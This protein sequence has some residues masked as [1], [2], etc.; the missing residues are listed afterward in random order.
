MK[1]DD[2]KLSDEQHASLLGRITRDYLLGRTPIPSSAQPVA[3]L[4]GGQPGSG[5][6]YLAAMALRELA[7]NAVRIDSDELRGYHPAYSRLQRQGARDAADLVHPDAGKWAVELTQAAVDGRYNLVIDGTMRDHAGV[8]RMATALQQ[9]GYRVEARVLAVNGY[10]SYMQTHAR[11]EM[12]MANV[13]LGRPTTKATH[14][15]AYSG[16]PATLESLER[17]NAVDAITLFNRDHGV[18]Y[19]NRQEDGQWVKMP[20]ARQALDIERG[21]ELTQDEKK[22]LALGWASVVNSQ[23]ARLAPSKDIEA[24]T[25]LAASELK[26]AASHGKGRGFDKL[27]AP[28]ETLK[29]QPQLVG[30]YA[31]LVAMQVEAKRQQL[32]IVQQ[33]V[34][35]RLAR[36]VDQ[37]TKQKPSLVKVSAKSKNNDIER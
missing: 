5:K 9:A 3:I 6:S 35:A 17:S 37:R 25:K 13:G 8:T 18:I 27:F 19:A 7:G 2:Y 10:V 22:E 30:R 29:Q 36:L 28:S 24:T 26:K 1:A 31:S 11:Y 12:Q 34:E 23:K 15:S 20:A 32:D 33:N 14:D 16:L 21:R 4:T